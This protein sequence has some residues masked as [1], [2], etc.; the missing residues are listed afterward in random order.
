MN[1]TPNLLCRIQDL[2]GSSGI[3]A[4]YGE[5][6][7]IYPFHLMLLSF[8]KPFRSTFFTTRSAS[9]ARDALF[10]K[11]YAKDWTRHQW[12]YPHQVTSPHQHSTGDLVNVYS[13]DHYFLGI[14]YVNPHSKIYG[15]FISMT[16]HCQDEHQ[17]VVDYRFFKEKLL[18]CVER[19]RKSKIGFGTSS[20]GVPGDTFMT[21]GRLVNSE[22]DF[23]PG[24]V[25]DVY[26]TSNMV[27]QTKTHFMDY[28]SKHILKALH[29][30]FQPNLVIERNDLVSRS[31]EDLPQVKKAHSA[32]TTSLQQPNTSRV[33]IQEIHSPVNF[34][35]FSVDLWIG[36]KTGYY[37]DQV[38]NRSLLKECVQDKRVLDLYCYVGSWSLFALHYGASYVIGWR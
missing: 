2:R 26:G 18:G 4:E 14:A 27:V 17:L 31:L 22:G 37:Y 24:L 6:V 30:L 7:P 19:R 32:D 35:R 1:L 36:Q 13:M 34:L 15:R 23:L 11:K 28:H 3:N 9:S 12:I 33:V 5:Y 20:S 38:F 29:L 16:P 21:N 25:V 10:V 8:T